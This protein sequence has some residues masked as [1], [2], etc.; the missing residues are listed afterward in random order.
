MKFHHAYRFA[1]D[2][3]VDFAGLVPASI[4]PIRS[5]V[6]VLALEVNAGRR[7][8]KTSAQRLKQDQQ[9][10][11]CVCTEHHISAGVNLRVCVCAWDIALKRNYV[12][13][14]REWLVLL[15]LY[16]K[17]KKHIKNMRCLL[18]FGA[19]G[20]RLQNDSHLAHLL[21]LFCMHPDGLVL[22]CRHT[23]RNVDLYT[24]VTT[25]LEYSLRFWPHRVS[26]EDS[27]F[28]F[29]TNKSEHWQQTF[30]NKISTFQRILNQFY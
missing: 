22:S 17:F 20:G 4:L 28:V 2:S 29:L 11:S 21:S 3:P 25:G 5:V 10:F 26:V 19:T 12:S 7:G 23:D 6:S 14:S 24:V 13:L 18:L 15:F 1:S 9:H 27:I 8:R 30:L 16:L